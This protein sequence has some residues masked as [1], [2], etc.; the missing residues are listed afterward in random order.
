MLPHK[1]DEWPTLFEKHIA[2]GHLDAATVLYASDASFVS[3][4]LGEV[5]K[6]RDA[7]RA[8]LSGLIEGTARLR[9]RV[10]KTVV[11][12][13]VTVLSTDWQITTAEGEEHSHTIEILRRQPDGTCLLAMGDTNGRR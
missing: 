11:A 2:A 5:I 3:P 8:V 1:P 7:I 13:D 10:V 12:G 4:K 9:G 6:D